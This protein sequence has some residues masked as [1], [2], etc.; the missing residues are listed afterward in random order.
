MIPVRTC[1]WYESEAEEAARFYTSLVPGSAVEEVMRPAAE[2]PA[3]LVHFTLGGVPFSAL[4]GG[5]S[6]A[7]THAASVV[8]EAPDQAETD[9]LW[10]AIL[11]NDGKEVQCG[12]ITD[13]W[14]VSWQII[15]QGFQELMFSA[16]AEANQRAYQAM[17]KM[18]RLDL[19]AVRA[20][21]EGKGGTV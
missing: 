9:R 15:P 11:E 6:V 18:I 10:Q 7:H 20:A 8:L 13:R 2:A 5:S 14:G 12:W 4:N 21:H 19:A 1:L 16:D 17:L 3:V